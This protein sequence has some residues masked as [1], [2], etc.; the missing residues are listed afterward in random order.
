MGER[1]PPIE[2]RADLPPDL[3]EIDYKIRLAVRLAVLDHKRAGNPVAT[4]IDGRVVQLPPSKIF[5]D[6]FDDLP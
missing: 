6:E 4:V 1:L 5:P 2:P 3:R